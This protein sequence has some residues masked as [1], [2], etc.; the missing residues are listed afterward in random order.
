MNTLSGL[1]IPES[2][3]EL[4][5]PLI[6][7]VFAPKIANVNISNGR[8]IDINFKEIDLPDKFSDCLINIIKSYTANTISLSK[9]R[10]LTHNVN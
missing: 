7:E 8:L 6:N 3:S 10:D 1:S 4:R 5:T 9:Y 2:T